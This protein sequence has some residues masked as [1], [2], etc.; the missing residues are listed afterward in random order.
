MK[1]FIRKSLTEKFEFTRAGYHYVNICYDRENHKGIWELRK[2]IDGQS[3]SFGFEVVKGIKQKIL[4]VIL[5]I[6]TLRMKVSALMVGICAGETHWEDQST[7]LKNY[8]SISI[9]KSYGNKKFNIIT[10]ISQ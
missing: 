10:E 8:K 9:I 2:T 1:S 3:R 4:T 5:S 7:D 6:P